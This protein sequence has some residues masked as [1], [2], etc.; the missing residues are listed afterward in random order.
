[1]TSPEQT[2]PS[3]AIFTASNAAALPHLPR[4]P[5]CCSHASLPCM[6]CRRNLAAVPAWLPSNVSLALGAS[7]AAVAAARIFKAFAR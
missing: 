7:V 3:A 2:S 5:D 6:C 1:M 4:C